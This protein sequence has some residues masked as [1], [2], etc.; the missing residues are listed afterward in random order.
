MH[1]DRADSD[2]GSFS[3]LGC[4]RVEAF[5]KDIVAGRGVGQEEAWDHYLKARQAETQLARIN[6]E[7]QQLKR[8][9]AALEE[10]KAKLMA[11]LG[12]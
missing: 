9:I 2:S 7:L 4:A 8:R 6:R 10:R 3:P 1:A 12:K 5:A 11:D